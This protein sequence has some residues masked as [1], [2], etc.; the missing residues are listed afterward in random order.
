MGARLVTAVSTTV[1]SWPV[2]SA[3]RLVKTLQLPRREME[4]V[5]YQGTT[6]SRIKSRDIDD[7]TYIDKTINAPAMTRDQIRALLDSLR[8]NKRTAGE[9][10]NIMPAF[11]L[12][13][14][15]EKMGPRAVSQI[16]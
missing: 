15:F 8:P 10:G 5:P 11:S 6:W 1:I 12:T 3:G 9:A 13:H 2:D 4:T 14:Y 16:L 7:E